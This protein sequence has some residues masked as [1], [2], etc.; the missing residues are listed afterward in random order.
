MEVAAAETS[1]TFAVVDVSEQNTIRD[2]GV[3]RP[4]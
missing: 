3:D 1:T 2:T 4:T